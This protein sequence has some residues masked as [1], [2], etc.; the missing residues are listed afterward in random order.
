M[1]W[2]PV[3]LD[4]SAIIKLIVPERESVALEAALADWPDWVSSRLAAV[5]CRRAL[6]RARA[7]RAAGHRADQVLA[8]ITLVRLDDPVL[9]LAETVG[10]PAL[11]TLD[12]LHLATAL[13]LGDDPDAFLT[14]D[15]RLAIAARRAGL[16]VLQPGRPG[17]AP[18]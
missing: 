13:S 18:R 10:T 11:R 2:L 6:R 16:N 4:T 5:E 1:S 7:P 14:Y 12:A 3:Y 15:D 17:P 8:A 9:K